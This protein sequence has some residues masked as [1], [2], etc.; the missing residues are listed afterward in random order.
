MKR[1]NSKFY[2]MCDKIEARLNLLT[3]GVLDAAQSEVE[4]ATMNLDVANE[5]L[6]MT[7]KT[8]YDKLVA[9]GYNSEEDINMISSEL[10]KIHKETLE[11]KNISSDIVPA[12]DIEAETKEVLK[13][14]EEAGEPKPQVE[15]PTV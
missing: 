2:E 14:D 1:E 15:E 13:S 8:I 9:A 5:K 12:S 3:E 10:K 7:A 4:K 11:N 6:R